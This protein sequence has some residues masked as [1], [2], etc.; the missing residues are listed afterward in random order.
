MDT[1][2]EQ[3]NNKDGIRQ[4]NRFEKKR[5]VIRDLRRRLVPTEQHREVNNPCAGY[6][7]E[8]RG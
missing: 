8:R 2:V 6:L 1:Y 4:R 5:S 3:F 7:N